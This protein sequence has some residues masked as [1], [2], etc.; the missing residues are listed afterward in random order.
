M[1]KFILSAILFI[2]MGTMAMAQTT[3]NKK[4]QKTP[5]ERAQRATDMLDKKLSLT[6]DQK[7]K[8]YALNLDDMKKVKPK[9]VKGEKRD[10]TA[11]KAAMDERDTKINSILDEKQRTSYKEWKEKRQL[12]MKDHAGKKR[13]DKNTDAPKSEKI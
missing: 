5:E 12:S 8:I 13:G 1:K 2:S 3:D 11:M 6:A 9:H 7:S 10:M 4:V